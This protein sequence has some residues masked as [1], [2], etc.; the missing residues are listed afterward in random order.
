MKTS[1]IKSM[2]L[3]TLLERVRPRRNQ[4]PFGALEERLVDLKKRFLV[5]V[6]KTDACWVWEGSQAS[7]GYGSFS[8]K[9][10]IRAHRLSWMLYRGDIPAGLFVCHKCDNPPCVNPAHLW[11][12]TNQENVID[13]V[14]KGRWLLGRKKSTH[15]PRGH[16]FKDAKISY[17]GTQICRICDLARHRLQDAKR[18]AL[19]HEKR[20]KLLGGSK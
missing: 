10:S 16:S 1:G 13:S 8:I 19:R 7:N 4:P 3:Q 15:C 11:L 6:R 2:Q 9:K 5:K 12:G 20:M 14:K 17:R 18:K